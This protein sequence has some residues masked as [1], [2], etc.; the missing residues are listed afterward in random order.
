MTIAVREAVPADAP[1]LA[2]LL[3]AIN[4]EPGLHPERITAESVR[5]DLIGDPRVALL[6]AE[7]KGV[8]AGFVSGHPFYD[9]ASSRWGM[10]IGDIYVAP[11]A[12]RRGIGR[13]LVAA[14]AAHAA[15]DGGAFLWWAADLGDELA[16][17]FHRGIGAEETP[18]ISFFIGDDDFRRL[19]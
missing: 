13:A 17:A 5:H 2:E 16:L 15:R 1:V 6:V 10:V 14:L 12:R 3:R 4:D 9:S 8:V 19:L 7:A 11:E 18:T